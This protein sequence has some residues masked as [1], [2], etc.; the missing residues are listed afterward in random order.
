MS[1]MEHIKNPTHAENF[2]NEV[3]RTLPLDGLWNTERPAILKTLSTLVDNFNKYSKGKSARICLEEGS[4]HYAVEF[5]D[6]DKELIKAFEFFTEKFHFNNAKHLVKMCKFLYLKTGKRYP[7]SEIFNVIKGLLD[8]ADYLRLLIE[9][10]LE[11][12]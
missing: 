11:K 2:L 4:R 7:R 10:E 8:K 12:S 9:S 6:E 1:V 5:L 3:I